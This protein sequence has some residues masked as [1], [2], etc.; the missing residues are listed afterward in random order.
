MSIW[1]YDHMLLVLEKN[2]QLEEQV[3]KGSTIKGGI[4]IA[5][6]V[7]VGIFIVSSVLSGSLLEVDVFLPSHQTDS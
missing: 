2:F 7:L 3:I 6:F 5:G 1:P 4:R